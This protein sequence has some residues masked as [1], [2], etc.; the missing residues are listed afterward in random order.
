MNKDPGL[1]SIAFGL[2]PK[3]ASDVTGGGVASVAATTFLSAASRLD[4]LYYMLTDADELLDSYGL[5]APGVAII[6]Y[7]SWEGN[8][9]KAHPSLAS[10]DPSVPSLVGTFPID[11]DMTQVPNTHTHTHTLT[12]SHVLNLFTIPT[13]TD[14]SHLISPRDA[15][16]HRHNTATPHHTTTPPQDDLEARLLSYTV[17]TMF[18]FG[19][20]TK[21]IIDALPIREHVLLFVSVDALPDPRRHKVS[22][23]CPH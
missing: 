3:N 8:M 17:P 15:I 7:G 5:Q 2:F 20:H 16:S 10:S 13:G 23:S 11:T 22:Q 4:H 18:T 19:E 21:H 14:T 12:H 1:A 6:S 9:D